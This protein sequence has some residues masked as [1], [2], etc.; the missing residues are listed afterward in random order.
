M[1]C[2]F[3]KN[4]LKSIA[5]L[6]NHKKN[7][8]KCLEIQKKTTN[9]IDSSL[10]LCVFCE[11]SFTKINT[12]YPVC[13]I[14]KNKDFEKLR[15]NFE[16]LQSDNEKLK[17]DFNVIQKNLEKLQSHTEK[18]EIDNE[19]LVNSEKSLQV[20]II[21][22]KEINI[23]LE[24]ENN[25]YKKDHDTITSLAKQ[26]K[27]TTNT[28]NNYNLSVYDDKIIKDRFTL[29]INNVK[30][31]ELYDGQKSIGRFVAPC[32]KNDDG[33]T[34]ISCTDSSRN[35]FVYKDSEGNINRDIKCKNLATLIE[36]I[37]TARVDELIKED[38]DK[39][40][41]INKI[42]SL[43][44]QIMDRREQIERLED[45]LLGFRKDTQKWHYVKSQILKKENENE[46]AEEELERLENDSEDV[47]I[48]EYHIELDCDEKLVIAADDIKEMSKDSCKF[49]KTISEFV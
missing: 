23:K 30:P 20:E 13:K 9:S 32:L 37:A 4:K 34:M 25:I 17:T 18:I 3:C 49:S 15:S 1:E 31:S 22:L 21:E 29:A 10:V 47:V 5:S 19:K 39:R 42:S 16:K 43:K 6:N 33:T 14:K 12:H 7:N 28:N 48:P 2:N 45:H 27:N 40:Y 41:K 44:K 46:L 35:V 36:P 38:S 24:T 26:P 8:K 11:K